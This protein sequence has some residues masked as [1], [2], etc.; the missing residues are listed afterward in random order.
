MSKRSFSEERDEERARRGHRAL[1]PEDHGRAALPRHD[2]RLVPLRRMSADCGAGPRALVAGRGRLRGLSPSIGTP[3]TT[4]HANHDLWSMYVLDTDDDDKYHDEGIQ[5]KSVKRSPY[6]YDWLGLGSEVYC[7]G[8]CRRDRVR[9]VTTFLALLLTVVAA[10]GLC[11]YWR[12]PDEA[13]KPKNF[14]RFSIILAVGGFIGLVGA[15]NYSS[16]LST[17]FED[18]KTDDEG[19]N[20][21]AAG[22][23]LSLS[24]GLIAM[25][26]G[27]G[28]PGPA[29]EVR[30]RT[31]LAA[32][33]E[34]GRMLS[35]RREEPRLLCR[36]QRAQRRPRGA[37]HEH[38]RPDSGRHLPHRELRVLDMVLGLGVVK[39]KSA[40]PGRA[41]ASTSSCFASFYQSLRTRVGF[42]ASRASGAGTA[43]PASCV[44]CRS[45]TSWRSRA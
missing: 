16:K 3:I 6:G 25:V 21:C 38:P 41:S 45:S 40:C 44:C 17:V 9:Q 27:A 35:G 19:T 13:A 1:R 37:G 34:V 2:Q 24:F 31:S 14:E 23:A 43:R 10:G 4:F 15:A 8:A 32:T 26:A 33:Q 42:A 22:C 29:T 36:A 28:R 18:L 30:E 12:S 39:A 7:E 11:R 20:T 5:I